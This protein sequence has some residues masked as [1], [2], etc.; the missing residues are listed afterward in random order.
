M[1]ILMNFLE[2]ELERQILRL[3]KCASP[4][5]ENLREITS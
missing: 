2:D 3:V 4:R 1:Y 5:I